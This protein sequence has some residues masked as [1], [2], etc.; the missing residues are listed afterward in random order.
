VNGDVRRRATNL[1]DVQMTVEKGETS[2]TGVTCQI[3]ASGSVNARHTNYTPLATKPNQIKCFF[4]EQLSER[5]CEQCEGLQNKKEKKYM[6]QL[7]TFSVQHT[8]N[9]IRVSDI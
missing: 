3:S 7:L 5:N 6:G 8:S 2:D 9:K 4:N 1:K